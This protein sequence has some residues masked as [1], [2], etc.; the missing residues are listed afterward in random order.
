MNVNDKMQSCAGVEGGGGWG[1]GFSVFVSNLRHA[2]FS[3]NFAITE[4]PAAILPVASLLP[5]GSI[6]TQVDASQSV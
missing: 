6:F 5:V 1:G 4:L 3:K 2:L